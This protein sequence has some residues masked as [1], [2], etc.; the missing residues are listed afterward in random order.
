MPH[1]PSA[2]YW[3]THVRTECYH[4]R[5]KIQLNTI[6]VGSVDSGFAHILLQM[7]ILFFVMAVG[8]VAKKTK[9]MSNEIDR[10]LS[11][12]ILSTSLPAMI[13]AS[14]LTAD[15][16]PSA[17]DILVSI[18]LSCASY[19]III[20]VALL[21]TKAMRVHDGHKGVFRFMMTFGNVGFVGFP[22]LSAIFGQQAIIYASIFNLPFSF[23]VF[24]V[25]A[26]FLAQDA[27][28]GAKVKM[29]LKTFLSPAIIASVVA[30]ALALLDVRGVPLV[31]DALDALGGLTVPGALLIVGSSLAGMPVRDLAGG[32]KLWIAS[33]FR[34]AITPLI[35]W[36]VFRNFVADPM[37]LTILVVVS[38]MPVATNG[39]MLC[40]QYGGDAKGMAQGTFVTTV[41]SIVSIPVLVAI[42]G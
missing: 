37:L 36:L 3:V 29:G 18:G 22:V 39:T 41:L 20:A 38:A 13:I 27:G 26:W 11:N 19:V 35:V 8:Y 12:L 30:I 14:V 1:A 2:H 6:K 4:S 24:T 9:V 21:A 40:Y 33:L 16:L 23:L 31:G 42:V 25:G 10:G 34:L 28:N 32:P 17:T 7:V 5:D 15:E